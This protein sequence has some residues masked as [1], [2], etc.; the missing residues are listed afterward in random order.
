M[1]APVWHVSVWLHA[2]ESL[3]VV[4]SG[5]G[6]FEQMPVPGLQT[7]GTWHWLKAVHTIGLDPVHA[8]SWQ[9]SDCVH[10][11]T[12]L[13]PV[14][15]VTFGFEQFPVPVSQRSDVQVFASPQS[16]GLPLTQAPVWQVSDSVQAL[17][18][19]HDEP[20]DLFGLEQTP[21]RGLQTPA[22]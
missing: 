11:F 16:F 4:P 22:S 19:L 2:F 8:P 5:A 3:H 7:P 12:S 21:F 13:H 6:G 9:E 17:A 10:E 20:S 1:Q 15:F 18:S 14:P